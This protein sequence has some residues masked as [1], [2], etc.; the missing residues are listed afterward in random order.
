[1]RR[2]A[3]RPEY[4]LMSTLPSLRKNLGVVLLTLFLDL[5]GFSIIFP[6]FP[7]MLDYYFEASGQSG[8]LGW[9][10]PRLDSLTGGGHY[11]AVLFGGILGSLYSGAQFIFCSH[12]G[13]A[14]RPHRKKTGSPAHLAG[15][16][17][18][19]PGMG[20]ERML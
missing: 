8:I 7:G 18:Q 16:L 15:D 19:L 10:V 4:P 1:M 5:V 14:F 2:R 13:P 12:L 3:S 9:A 17:G 20:V 6:L 11:T